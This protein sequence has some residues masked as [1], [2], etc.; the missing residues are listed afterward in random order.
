MKKL[1]V[2]ALIIV[3]FT[4][5]IYMFRPSIQTEPGGVASAARTIF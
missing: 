3:F 4:A 2:L 5:F 1:F